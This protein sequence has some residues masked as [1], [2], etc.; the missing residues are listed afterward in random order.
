MAVVTG[1]L[2]DQVTHDPAQ[3]DPPPVVLLLGEGGKTV[4]TGQRFRDDLVGDQEGL[5][6]PPAKNWLS[7]PASTTA[8]CL[9]SP[10]SVSV[11]GAIGVESWTVVSPEHFQRSVSR[12]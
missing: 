1:V 6:T 5:A 9:S 11:V 2:L 8:A 3:G 7:Q 10:P 12:W 4:R